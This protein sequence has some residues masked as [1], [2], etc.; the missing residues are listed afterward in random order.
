MEQFVEKVIWLIRS[1][2]PTESVLSRKKSVQN[3]IIQ[4]IER[5]RNR[6]IYLYSFT[7]AACILFM[8]LLVNPVWVGLSSDDDVLWTEVITLNGQRDTVQLADGSTIIL[9]GGSSLKY[10][11]YFTKKHRR[12]KLNGEGYFSITTNKKAPFEVE[13]GAVSIKVLGTKFNLK[14]YEADPVVETILEEGHVQLTNQ[15][16]EEIIN[17]LPDDKVSFDKQINTFVKTKTDGSKAS[18]WKE[19]KYEF[20]S[21][22]FTEIC[23]ML[24]RGFGVTFIL[25]DEDIADKKF[26]ATFNKNESVKDIL[27]IFQLSSSFG[28]TINGKT[29]IIK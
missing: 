29:I 6:R 20:V 16:T 21:M 25:E 24:E 28:Y 14:A 7:V 9:N 26:T 22:P 17:M 11:E 4:K 23:K 3:K 18:W 5:R 1:D 27:Q 2:L 13:T 8:L 10:P 15:Q 12:V 19:Q